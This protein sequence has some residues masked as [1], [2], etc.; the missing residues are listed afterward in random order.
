MW[1]LILAL[2]IAIIIAGFASLNSAPVSVNFLLWKAPELSLAIVVLFSV[3]IGVLMAALFGA[4]QY[5][6]TA[7]RIKELEDRI[8]ELGGK[9]IEHEKKEEQGPPQ[10]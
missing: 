1:T 9:E 10:N 7:Q 3:L 6:K 5:L 4:S 8:R 2:L